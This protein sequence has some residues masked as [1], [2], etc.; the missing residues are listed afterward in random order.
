M[1]KN[2]WNRAKE[3]LAKQGYTNIQLDNIEDRIYSEIVKLELFY[4]QLI[5]LYNS[6]SFFSFVSGVFVSSFITITKIVDGDVSEAFFWL[7][8]IF[9]VINILIHKI[10]FGF[11]MSKKIILYSSLKEKIKSELWKFM[12]KIEKYDG[13]T[14]DEAVSRLF[15]RFE[16]IKQKL[17]RATVDMLSQPTKNNGHSEVSASSANLFNSP[18]SK[19]NIEPATIH[20]IPS[21]LTVDNIDTKYKRN[22][23]DSV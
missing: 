18:L 15:T 12:S 14:R 9:S 8:F 1:K 2:K 16:K 3:R 5:Y 23:A 10:L 20:E 4:K 13:L 17:D 7:S 6:I 11:N 21:K 19:R 22:S